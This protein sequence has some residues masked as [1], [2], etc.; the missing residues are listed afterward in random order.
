MRDLMLTLLTYEPFKV[1]DGDEKCYIDDILNNCQSHNSNLRY[2]MCKDLFSGFYAYV[3]KGN[4]KDLVWLRDWRDNYFPNRNINEAEYPILFMKICFYSIVNGNLSDEY[5]MGKN[6]I[7]YRTNITKK[8]GICTRYRKIMEKS[9]FSDIR[10]FRNGRKHEYIIKVIKAAFYEASRQEYDLKQM[11]EADYDYRKKVEL[12]LPKKNNLLTFVD[13]FAGTGVVAASVDALEKFVNDADSGAACFL[14]AMS[15]NPEELK[16]RF[17]SLHNN[18]VSTDMFPPGKYY[19]NADFQQHMNKLTNEKIYDRNFTIRIRNNYS[20]L[21]ELVTSSEISVR[22]VD[23]ENPTQLTVDDLKNIVP[24]MPNIKQEDLVSEEFIYDVGVAWLFI[25][26]VHKT[27]ANVFHVTNMDSDTYYT[28]LKEFLGIKV[29]RVNGVGDPKAQYLEKLVLSPSNIRF[30]NKNY[31]KNIEG[32]KIS[33]KD[34]SDIIKEHSEDFL[35]LDSPYFLTTDYT[36]PFQDAEHKRMLDLLRES[37]C[38]WLFSMKFRAGYCDKFT[39]SE[40]NKKRRNSGQ[41]LIENYLAYYKGFANDFEEDD[42][43]NLYIQPKSLSSK[44][45]SL[46]VIFLY[47]DSANQRNNDTEEI[48]ICNFDVRRVIPYLKHDTVI[49]PYRD[50]ISYVSNMNINQ[51]FWLVRKQAL[52]WR[53]KEIINNYASG[54]SV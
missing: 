42:K 53:E 11:N 52:E 32:A 49:M 18:F 6:G 54:K 5:F 30:C 8:W 31:F 23:F 2:Q 19:T 12:K 27:T 36:V 39:R 17:A 13:V 3:N 51:D 21:L 43:N 48:M 33:C 20:G 41:R 50:F 15:H 22:G 44:A 34:F 24:K 38:K 45:D 10:L 1:I 35:Y 29:R 40:D 46:Y 14:Y 7:D 4:W 26:S 16:E 25:H 37:D 47:N 28:Y 9:T